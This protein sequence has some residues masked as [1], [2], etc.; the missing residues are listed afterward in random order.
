MHATCP[1]GT[2]GASGGNESSY[3]PTFLPLSQHDS[4]SVKHDES[5]PQLL[6]NSFKALLRGE[7]MRNSKLAHVTMM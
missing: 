6:H 3:R 4:G 2:T 1:T 7:Q 5:S